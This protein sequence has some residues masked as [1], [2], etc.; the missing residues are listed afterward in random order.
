MTRGGLWCL[1]G[2]GVLCAVPSVT[3]AQYSPY[4]YFRHGSYYEPH[5]YSAPGTSPSGPS[6]SSANYSPYYYFRHGSYNEPHM[7]N[8]PGTSPSDYR[9]T[10]AYLYGD[11]YSPYDYLR[12]GTYSMP[13]YYGYNTRF[14]YP[15]GPAYYGYT[16]SYSAAA[17]MSRVEEEQEVPADDNRRILRERS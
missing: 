15:A 17:V 6:V 9:G 13:L 7:Y 11:S 5:M 8:A 1:L 2:A 10:A 16:P 14:G 12:H 3:S 4:N